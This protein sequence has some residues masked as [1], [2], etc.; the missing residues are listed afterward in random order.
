M[1]LTQP[2]AQPLP[3][4]QRPPTAGPPGAARANDPAH[5]T[6][7]PETAAKVPLGPHGLPRVEAEVEAF[8]DTNFYTN[9]LGD[10]RDHGGIFVA[11]YAVL[12]V[13]TACEVA[14]KFPGDYQVEFR[15]S[16]RWRRDASA[17]STSAPGMGIEITQAS[18]D[19]WALIDRFIQKREPII[20]EV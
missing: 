16:V 5:K 2:A 13:G 9:F 8:S 1:P 20:Q 6:V 19:A 10:I 4:T 18:N 15:G 12:A 11:T 14:L 3:L 7:F 17:E